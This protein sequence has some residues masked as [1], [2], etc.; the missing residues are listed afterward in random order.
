MPWLQDY[1]DNLQGLAPSCARVRADPQVLYGQYTCPYYQRVL[2][3]LEL[4]PPVPG[5]V[6]AE[7]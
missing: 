3:E 6:C 1:P 5:E 7:D 4:A 2:V